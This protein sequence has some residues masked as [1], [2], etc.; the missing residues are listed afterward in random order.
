MRTLLRVVL[1]IGCCI[2]MSTEVYAAAAGHQTQLTF[3]AGS[4]AVNPGALPEATATGPC[5][6]TTAMCASGTGCY[7]WNPVAQICNARKTLPVALPLVRAQARFRVTAFPSGFGG[8]DFF[9]L[10]ESA[11]GTGVYVQFTNTNQLRLFSTGSGGASDLCGP[12]ATPVAANTWYGVRVRAQKS[13]AATVSLDLLNDGGVVLDSVSCNNQHAGGGSFTTLLVGSGNG[14]GAT[15]DITIDDVDVHNDSGWPGNVRWTFLEPTANQS[16]GASMT[17]CSGAG[18]HWQCIDE[19]PPSDGDTS[20]LTKSN[21]TAC[22]FTHPTA[23][24]KGITE[25]IHGTLLWW[26]AE[27]TAGSVTLAG[28]LGNID[29][30]PQAL[31]ATYGNFFAFNATNPTTGTAW[32]TATLNSTTIGFRNTTSGTSRVTE[33]RWIVG[34]EAPPPPAPTPPTYAFTTSANNPA[35]AAGDAFGEAVAIAAGYVVV[36][37]PNQ[38]KVYVYDHGTGQLLH[39]LSSPNGADADLFG[40]SVAGVAEDIVVGAPRADV[41]AT[42]SG[43]A[44]VYNG[45]TGQ[46]QQT[47]ANPS[48]AL[49][50][51]FG[52]AV[53]AVGTFIVVGADGDDTQGTNAGAAYLY[54]EGG[55]T[56]Q[57]IFY[58]PA[59]IGTSAFGSTV[60][61]AGGYALVGDPAHNGGAGAAYVFDTNIFGSFGMHLLTILNPQP[62][63]GDSFGAALSGIGAN[64]LIGAPGDDTT[65]TDSG[66]A[67]LFDGVQFLT[68]GVPNPN[69]GA[70]TRT[71]AN[72]SPSADDQ[73]GSSVASGRDEHALVGAPFDDTAGTNAGAAYLFNPSNG[74]LMSTFTSPSP[75]AQA[76][77]GA[78]ADGGRALLVGAPLDSSTAANAGRAYLYE[79]GIPVCTD[80]DPDTLIGS[81]T[82]VTAHPAVGIHTNVT[83]EGT[84][85]FF[86]GSD[87]WY[88]AT[89]SYVWDP[90]TGQVTEQSTSSNNLFC[91]GHASLTDGRTIVIGGT[92]I[93]F[94]GIATSFIFDPAAETWTKVAN[95][96]LTRWYPTATTLADG[97]ILATS[98]RKA[99]GGNANIPELY[100]AAGNTWTQMGASAT[101]DLPLYPHMFQLPNGKV[102]QAGAD[103][104]DNVTRTLDVFNETWSVV[105]N[106]FSG[107]GSSAMYQPGKVL[108]SGGFTPGGNGIYGD[109]DDV[110]TANAGI[111]D[112]NVA[113]PAWDPV[114]PMTAARLNHNLVI[115]PDGTVLAVGGSGQIDDPSL[116]VLHAELFN[117]TTESWTREACMSVPRMY[118]SGAVLL[119][120]ARVLAQGGNFYPSYQVYTPPYLIFPSRPTIGSAPAMVQYGEQFAVQTPEAGTIASVVFMRPGAATH[121]FDQNQRRVPAAFTSGSGSLTVTA[122]PDSNTA[123]PG[124]Y[125]LFIVNSGGT[126][127]VAKFVQLKGCG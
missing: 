25:T 117:P 95:M 37:N 106:S 79:R 61:A 91:A 38:R 64:P 60:G 127:S 50:D 78:T 27:Q 24:A 81:W 20:F 15:A 99:G 119:P 9:A 116:A 59:P 10:H 3:E 87:M 43:A 45:I 5:T 34:Y 52:I 125:M 76:L 114:P 82:P 101:Q 86:Q 35:P 68:G 109:A 46:L 32:T 40:V 28:R 47:L 97:R 90:S 111:I 17:G 31:A 19:N 26:N 53:A 103:G 58:K 14:F 105:G 123:P 126:P 22:S 36:G 2:A 122:P 41:G 1:V 44:Y 124:F 49:Q 16:C 74:V 72:P 56:P 85:L 21:M 115:L 62:A 107:V 100:D 4:A 102:F 104:G 13:D 12:L 30:G 65:G 120:D 66:A 7:R 112:M 63:A 108:K 83:P 23:A 71:F 33:S 73:F 75:T 70:L 51:N 92:A 67:Y 88:E 54:G 93:L 11:F 42:D 69:F 121:A 57:A 89:D 96:A 80:N 39:T 98:G 113:T 94:D 110:V 48:P 6:R 18:N 84:V 55:S 118:H 8:Y 29:V 77:F